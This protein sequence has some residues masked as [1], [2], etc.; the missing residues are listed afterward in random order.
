MIALTRAH[1]GFPGG[2]VVGG[3]PSTAG[4]ASSIPGLGTKVPLAMGQVSLCTTMKVSVCLNKT[5]YSQKSKK[6]LSA[7]I[8]G[9]GLLKCWLHV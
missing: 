3:S 8:N 6:Y 9:R 2:P 7:H 5:Q 4:D 1:G